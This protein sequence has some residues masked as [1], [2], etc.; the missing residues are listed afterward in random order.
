MADIPR[1]LTKIEKFIDHMARQADEIEGRGGRLFASEINQDVADT[2]LAFD[3][4]KKELLS[5]Q[6]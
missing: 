6:K 3:Q 1:L 2:K 4:L 5:G